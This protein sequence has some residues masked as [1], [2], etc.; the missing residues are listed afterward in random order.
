MTVPVF[1]EMETHGEG[2]LVFRSVP[3]RVTDGNIRLRP[4]RIFDGPFMRRAFREKEVFEPNGMTRPVEGSWF[5]VWWW[6]KH[7]FSFS[8]CIEIDSRRSGFVGFYNFSPGRCAEIALALFEKETRGQGYGRRV[9]AMLERSLKRHSLVNT[10]LA[11]VKENNPAA[12]GFWK[13]VGF[14]VETSFEEEGILLMSKDLNP[15]LHR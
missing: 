10:L 12:A 3:R 6:L 13:R 5:E 2:Q 15:D 7:A 8:Y 9:F 14:E 11:R 4:L 1:A